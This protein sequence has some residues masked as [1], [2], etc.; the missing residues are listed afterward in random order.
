MIAELVSSLEQAGEGS[1]ELDQAVHEALGLP[2]QWSGPIN[3]PRAPQ[4]VWSGPHYT[5][6]VGDALALAAR[7]LPGWGRHMME[8]AHYWRAHVSAPGDEYTKDQTARASTPALALCI[9]ILRATSKLSGGAYRKLL[10]ERRH[11]D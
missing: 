6:H 8:H 1:R 4:G 7:V 2:G 11:H 9:A 5:H 10:K 3:P